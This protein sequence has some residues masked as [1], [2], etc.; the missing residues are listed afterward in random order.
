MEVFRKFGFDEGFI[1]WIQECT[2]SSWIVPTINGRP[3][4]FFQSSRGLRQGCPLSPLLYILMVESLSKKLEHERR[5]GRLPGIEFTWG[6]K[7]INHSQFADD[8]LIL[9]T[10]SSIIE[11]IFKRVLHT[12]LSSSSSKINSHKASLMDQTLQ[13]ISYGSYQESLDF[14]TLI[15]G[16]LSF[17]WACQV[18]FISLPL[19]LGF[20]L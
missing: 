15:N 17:I 7:E 1:N 9:I 13:G 18:H 10:S 14:S 6:I 8:T 16:L 4:T 11:E 20:Q 12:F 5:M 3:C 19:K 2:R